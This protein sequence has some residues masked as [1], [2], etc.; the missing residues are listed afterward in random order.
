MFHAR[1]PT[2]LERVKPILPLHRLLIDIDQFELGEEGQLDAVLDVEGVKLI[3]D[4]TENERRHITFKVFKV[5]KMSQHPI[6]I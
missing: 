1:H 5:S 4:E 6:R 3:M 2:G